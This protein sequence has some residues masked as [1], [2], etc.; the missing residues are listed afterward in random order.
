MDRMSKTKSMDGRVR[1]LAPANT[2]VP[3]S[4]GL[5]RTPEF[6]Q[7]WTESRERREVGR[8]LDRMRRDAEH[9]QAELAQ[10]MGK[11]QAFISRMESGRGPM[12]KAQH[13]ALWARHCGFMTAYAFVA[14][15]GNDDG[16]LLHELM[17]I[18]QEEDEAAELES[19]R[20]VVLPHAELVGVV[21]ES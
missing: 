1:N 8:A 10:L 16:L 5:E 15:E 3:F 20:D 13:I 4:R 11:D 14:K 12:P 21:E 18:A 19:V 7:A 9:T 17:P 6:D 2:E